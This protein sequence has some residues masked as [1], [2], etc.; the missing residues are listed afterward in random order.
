[1]TY[2]Q[3]V[4]DIQTKLETHPM[5]RTVKFVSPIEWINRDEVA[6]LP[7]AL[8]QIDSGNFNKGREL[9]YT[10]QFWFLDKSGSEAEFETEVVSDQH[11]VALDIVNLIR[12]ENSVY[13]IENSVSW[14]AISE[15]FEDYLSGVTSTINLSSISKY[16]ACNFPT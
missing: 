10:C 8:Y 4:K 12:K 1:M 16:D 15:K 14:T 7:V 5:I 3:V 13:T 11:S 9:V 2:N 6:E